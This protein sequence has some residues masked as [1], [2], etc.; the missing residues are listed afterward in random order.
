MVLIFAD[1]VDF[2]EAGDVD[3]FIVCALVVGTIGQDNELPQETPTPPTQ[4]NP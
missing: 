2:P 4:P 3:L 1:M